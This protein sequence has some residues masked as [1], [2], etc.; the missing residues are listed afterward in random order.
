MMLKGLGDTRF[1]R[2][3]VRIGIPLVVAALVL[4]PL[5][6]AQTANPTAE[7]LQQM[8]EGAQNGNL[9][10]APQVTPQ[11]T[12][13][14]P[15]SQAPGELAQSRLEQIMSQ[16]AGVT[17]H[18]FGYDQL[19]AGRSIVLPQAGAP[20]DDYTL[21]AGDEIVVSLRGQENN[22][23]RVYVNRDGQIVLPRLTPI[24]AA[25]RRLGSVRDDIAAAVHRAYVATDA[26]V[27]VGQIRQISVYVTGEVNSPGVRQLT[28]LSTA[29]DAILVSGGIKKTG[30]LR[31]V[32]IVRGGREIPLDLY[33]FLTQHG[34]LANVT[35]VDGDRIIVPALGRT[36]AVAGWVRQPAI[37][38]LAPGTSAIS[39]SSLISLAG[40][41]EVRGK[42]RLSVL[43]LEETGQSAMT[44]LAGE[45][46]AVRDSE[47]LFALPGAQQTRSQAILSGG[48]PLAGQYSLNRASRLSDLLSAPGA[49]GEAPYTLFGVIVRKDPATLLRELVAF[50]PLAIVNHDADLDLLSDDTIRVFSVKEARLMFAVVKAFKERRGAAEEALRAPRTAEDVALSQQ[51]YTAA[52][53]SSGGA[54]PTQVLNSQQANGDNGHAGTPVRNRPNDERE[55]IG[56]LSRMMLGDTGLVAADQATQ[57][58][59]NGQQQP[60]QQPPMMMQPQPYGNQYQPPMAA[61]AQPYGNYPPQAM[62]GQYG[63]NPYGQPQYGMQGPM[64]YYPMQLPNQNQQTE[65]LP[66]NMERDAVG[67]GEIPTNKEVRTFGQLSR[68]LGIDPLVLVHFLM[69]HEVTINGAVRGPGNYIV[70]PGVNLGQLVAA[71]GGTALWA[72]RSGVQLTSTDVD[73]ASGA[74]ATK[75]MTLPLQEATLSNYVVHPHDD[76]RFNE[77]FNDASIGAVTVQGEVRHTGT[78]QIVRGEHLSDLLLQAGGLTDVA[79]PYGAV[80]LRRSAAAIERDGYRRAAQDIQSALLVAMTR[81]DPTNRM[82]ADAFSAMQGFVTQ[83][84]TQVPLGRVTITADPTVLAVKPQEDILLEPGDVLYIPQRPS[85]VSV[86]GEVMQPGSYAYKPNASPGD[87]IQRAG[88]Y[89]QFADDDLTFVVLPDGTANKVDRSWLTF[90]ATKLPPGSAIVVPRDIDPL[91]IRALITQAT[92]ILSQLA[93]TAASLAVI[94]QNNG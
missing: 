26:F 32:R 29:I 72:D 30:S 23:Y 35:L 63:A 1:A 83:L 47:I 76:L 53:Q 37:Y 5:A 65:P 21:G 43:R 81:S 79:Y 34:T 16:R 51:Q 9:G 87:Y 82:S 38:E 40:G 24:L 67:P 2:Y 66:N 64:P 55:D 69:D 11:Q 90:N 17:L 59:Q 13:I 41:F 36:V 46:G 57:D 88:G 48:S 58:D 39:V 86:L 85:T 84:R 54:V 62:Q 45:S 33:A 77:I 78:Y 49:L 4:V 75:Q 71:A 80:F 20:Q 12:I 3:C 31:N 28:G 44:A 93:V 22:Q 61:G 56:E 89:A 74:A 25:G 50:T 91:D 15:I 70:G 73:P 27:T 52:V 18:Q 68:Q 6:Y 8:L 14:E 7:Q 42:Y 60:Q 19:G 92:T 94:S 10:T